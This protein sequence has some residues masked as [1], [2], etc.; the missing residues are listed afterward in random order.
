MAAAL[1][2]IKAVP[3]G[4]TAWDWTG[5]YSVTSGKFC[6]IILHNTTTTAFHMI[7]S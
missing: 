6:D 5:V 3:A 7:F 1:Q 2:S 4:W